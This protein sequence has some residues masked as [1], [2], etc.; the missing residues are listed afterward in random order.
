MAM[1]E[2]VD[3]F[4]KELAEAISAAVAESPQVEACRANAREAGYDMRHARSRCG[5]RQHEYSSCCDENYH[6]RTTSPG[7]E[8]VRAHDQ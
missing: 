2:F 1:N 8:D 3:R 4:A 5:F 7:A 6:A